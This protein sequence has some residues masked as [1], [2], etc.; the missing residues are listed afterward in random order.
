[1]HYSIDA[2]NAAMLGGNL[3]GV[4]TYILMAIAG[5]TEIFVG[6]YNGALKHDRIAP[7]VWQMIY[8]V[9]ASLFFVVPIAWFSEYLNLIPKY[10][11]E[12]GI[13]YQKIL[14][15]FCWLPALTA[16]FT[17]FFVGR[18]KT[19]IITAIVII[20][21]VVNIVLD[22]VLIF[23]YGNIIPSMGCRGAAWATIISE[24]LQALILAANFWNKNN[25]SIYGTDR[26][27]KFDKK[28]FLECFKIG[29]P[30]S[31]GR[32]VEI[33]AWYLVYVAL[34]YVSKE[35]GTVHGIAST[36]YIFFA[37]ICEGLSKGTAAIASNFIG[38]RDLIS[39]QKAFRR[40]VFITL[41]LCLTVMSPLLIIP[42]L[43]FAGLKMLNR[44]LTVF[45][46]TMAVIFRILF[47]T[48]TLEALTC[49]SWGVLF[50]G[51]DTWYPIVVNLLCLGGFVVIPVSMLFVTGQLNSPELVQFL[52]ACWNAACLFLLYRRYKSLKWYQPAIA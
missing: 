7:A 5:T 16:A 6:R 31:L 27:S 20:G 45:Y 30:M 35:L 10:Y 40:L 9:A 41:I 28:L 12:D 21:A 4:Y 29:F 43:V 49:T 47:V 34:S 46:P 22:Y 19:K 44:D 36:V 11:A 37:F 51:G 39:I 32:A 26:N 1:M 50:A 42:D 25:R 33:L 24:A 15:Y 8:F 14:T 23:G 52:S 17:G 18:G 13:A 48:V 38:R 2:M 3:T